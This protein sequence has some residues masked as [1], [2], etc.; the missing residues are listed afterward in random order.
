MLR[1][2]IE[3]QFVKEIVAAGR[4]LLR[5]KILGSGFSFPEH[6]AV[7]WSGGCFVFT[8]YNSVD[9]VLYH[10]NPPLLAFGGAAVGFISS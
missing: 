1:F 4:R 7:G 3:Q 2:E 10:S 8:Q 9:S 6:V 5:L